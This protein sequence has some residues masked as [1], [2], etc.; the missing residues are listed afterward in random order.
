MPAGDKTGPDREG[1]KTGRRAGYCAGFEMPG[2][3][4]RGPGGMRRRRYGF[5]RWRRFDGFY[6]MPPYAGFRGTYPPY[7]P[8]SE[9][10]KDKALKAEEDWLLE[11]LEAVRSQMKNKEEN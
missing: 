10:D 1:P 7:A 9:E 3:I 8:M 11:Q 4:F 2:Y 5:R 6:G